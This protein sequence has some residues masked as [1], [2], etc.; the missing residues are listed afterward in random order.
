MTHVRLQGDPFGDG[1]EARALRS[2]LLRAAGR[3]L[4]VG[5]SL[6]AVPARDPCEGERSVDVGDGLRRW[7]TATRLEE[8][9]VAS[10][11]AAASVDVAATAPVV[12][13]A[14]AA[15]RADAARLAGLAWPQACAVIPAGRDLATDDLIARV[16]AALRWAGVAAPAFGLPEPVLRPWLALPAAT[17]TCVVHVA[18][19]VFAC[20]SD[21]VVEGFAAAFADRGLRLRLVLPHASDATVRDL[22]ACAGEAAERVDVERGPLRPAHVADAA[23]VVQPYRRL[24][25]PDLLVQALASGRPVVAARFEATAPLLGAEAAFPV[26][27]RYARERAVGRAHFVPD[28]RALRAAW[29][30]ALGE[31]VPSSVGARGRSHVVASFVDERPAAPPPAV[32][33]LRAARPLVVLE[34]PIFEAS[35]TAEQTIATAEALATRGDV[36]LRVVPRGPFRR[37]LAWLR[38]RAPALESRL[39]RDPGRADLWVSAGWPSRADRPDCRRWAVRVDWGYGALPLELTPHVTEEADDVI[40]H[41]EQVRRAICAAGRAPESTHVLPHGVDRAMRP[42]ASP[43]ARITAF[44]AGRPAVLFCGG[45]VWRQGLDVFLGAVLAARAAGHELVVVVQEMDAEQDFGAGHLGG[46]LDRF[47]ATAGTPPLLRVSEDLSRAELASLYASCDVLLHPARGDQIAAP[48]REARACGLPV[49]ATGDVA[50]ARS[51]GGAGA[52]LVDATRRALELPGAFLSQPWVLEPDAAGAAA[53]LQQTLAALEQERAAARARASDVRQTS[54]WSAAA[55]AIEALA[56]GEQ[57]PASVEP[58]VP[59]P[60]PPA[61]HAPRARG[62]VLSPSTRPAAAVRS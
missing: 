32:P 36:D 13:F 22:L 51:M 8:Q 24:T 23:A 17:P 29:A 61:H 34:G 3:G 35:A 59:L 44:K 25:A 26:G 45:L 11:L 33:P 56:R 16:Q 52:R 19:D 50:S 27:G 49:I 47:E 5:L 41:S 31:P 57:P 43:D 6:A 62:G 48:V 39:S 1:A 2:L 54:C 40:V 37:G 10:L 21:L 58:T 53:Q 9:E 30:A 20:G 42:E 18:D 4:R 60:A 28:R 55:A 7:R 15:E 14:P 38:D 46:L 12:T